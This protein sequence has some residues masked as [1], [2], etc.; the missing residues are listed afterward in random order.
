MRVVWAYVDAL[1]LKPLDQKIRAVG[2]L[3]WHARVQQR[4]GR[5]PTHD[6]VDC[7]FATKAEITLVE[8]RGSRA[9]APIH[10]ADRLRRAGLDPF[11][12][13]RDDTD[14]SFACRQRMPTEAAQQSY[15]RRAAIAEFPRRG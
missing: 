1:D 2:G 8:Q 10:G 5:P 9:Q 6:L 3:P 14:E 11:A 4:Y 12:R 7:G 15:R 13:R